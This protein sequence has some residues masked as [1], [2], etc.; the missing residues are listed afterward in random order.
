[1]VIKTLFFRLH[2][3]E[4]RFIGQGAML[5]TKF[6]DNGAKLVCGFTAHQRRFVEVCVVKG[7]ANVGK[8]AQIR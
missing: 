7:N 3:L 8:Y 2:A 5:I 6:L 4:R 1:M